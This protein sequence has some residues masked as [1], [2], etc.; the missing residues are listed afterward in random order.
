MIIT[1]FKMMYDV[2]KKKFDEE[3]PDREIRTDRLVI[4]FFISIGTGM[5]SAFFGVGGGIITVP[6]LIYIIGLYPRRAIG[7]SAFMI[8]ITS[9]AGFI[10]YYLL[11]IGSIQFFGTALRTVPIIDYSMAII[12]GIVVMIGAY[13]GSSWGLA[14]LKTKNVQIIFIIIVLFVGVQLMLRAAGYI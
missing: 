12:L 1:G 6:V 7:T 11:S 2:Y 3:L 8:I 9:M 5:V 13:L 4:A 14:A 10:C